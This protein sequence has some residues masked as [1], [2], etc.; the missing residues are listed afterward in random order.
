MC[1]AQARVGCCLMFGH[2]H[3]FLE[4]YRDNGKENEN[5]CNGLYRVWGLVFIVPFFLLDLGLEEGYWLLW[6]GLLPMLMV[7]FSAS[8]QKS[9][10][11]ERFPEGLLPAKPSTEG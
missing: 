9:A 4:L 7:T 10:E 6:V 5:D 3:V 1:P 8:N 11:P 2:G